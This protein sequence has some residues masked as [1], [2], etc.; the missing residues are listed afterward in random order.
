MPNRRRAAT[1]VVDLR[2]LT[3]EHPQAQAAGGEVMHG[4]DPMGEVAAE[5]LEFP[6]L[7]VASLTT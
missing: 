3:G 7:P 6:D 4:V 1:V 5:T 2:A